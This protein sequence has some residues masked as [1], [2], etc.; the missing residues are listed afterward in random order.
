[1]TGRRTIERRARIFLGCERESEQGWMRHR[2]MW[3][4]IC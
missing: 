4:F 2:L 3:S 1:M